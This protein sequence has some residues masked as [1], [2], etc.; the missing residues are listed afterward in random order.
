[1]ARVVQEEA[2]RRSVRAAGE[3]EVRAPPVLVTRRVTSHRLSSRPA[4]SG[5]CSGALWEVS[6]PRTSKFEPCN[7]PVNLFLLI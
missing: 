7:S 4:T 3:G 1:M 6:L 5:T 2:V